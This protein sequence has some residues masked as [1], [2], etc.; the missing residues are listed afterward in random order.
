MRFKH[1]PG[2]LA[3]IAL[4]TLLAA[5]GGGGGGGGGDNDTPNRAPVSNAGADQSVFKGGA[6]TLDGSTSSDADGNSLSYRWTQSSG[7][8]VSLSSGTTSRPTFTAPAASGTLVF[9]LVVNDGRVDSTADTVQVTVA[10]RAPVAN[11]GTDATI[12]AGQLFTLDAMGSTDADT[13]A[14]TYTWTQLSG[15]AV[16]LTAVSNGRVR[17]T[18]PA[19]VSQLSFGV[20]ANDGEAGSTQDV[21]A[22]S[23]VISAINSPPVAQAY[24][25]FSMPKR[26]DAYLQGYGY[27]PENDPITFRWRQVGGPTVT[28]TNANSWIASFVAPETPAVLTFEFNVSDGVSISNTEVVVVTVENVAPDVY[29]SALSPANPRT[30]DDIAVDADFFDADSDPLTVTYTW[31]RNGTVVPSVTGAIFPASETTR[32]DV[33][34]VT[35]TANDGTVSTTVDAT[36]TILD[37]PPVL[38]A[39]A[40]TD[41]NYGD[42]V[43]FTVTASGDD[44]GDA[45]GNYVVRL[46]PAGFNVSGGGAAQWVA[47][48]PM[49]D[50]YVDVAWTVGL[51]DAPTAGVSGVIRVHHAAREVPIMRTAGGVPQNRELLVVTDLDG[52]GTD[53][54][55]ISDGRTLYVR[56]RSGTEFPENW[57]YPFSLA[58]VSNGIQSIAAANVSGDANAEIYVSSDSRIRMLDGTT[59]RLV[60]EYQP[61][62]V[63]QCNALRVADLEGDGPKEL[64]CLGMVDTYNSNGAGKIVVLNAADLSLKDTINQ[65]GLGTSMDVGNLDSDSALEIVTSNGYV[66]SGAT[67]INEWAYGPQ[68]G[69]VV[70]AGDVDGD[71]VEEIIAL[72][73]TD[74]KV[75]SAVT[76]NQR[77]TFTSGYCCGLGDVRVAE[78]GGDARRE[79]FIGDSQ[80][81]AVSAH[82]LNTTTQAFEQL[83]T[84]PSQGYGISGVAIGNVDADAN[85][86][87][88]WGTDIG[89]SANDAMI[90]AE[91]STPTTLTLQWRSD[92]AGQFTGPFVGGMLTRTA[93]GVRKVMFASQGYTTNTSGTRLIGLDPATGSPALS[94][95]IANTYYGNASIEVGDADSDGIDEVFISASDSYTPFYATHDF[96]S[97]TREWTSPTGYTASNGMAHADVTGDGNVD[98]ASMGTDARV[99]IFNVAQ[100]SVVWQSPQLEYNGQDVALGDVDEDGVTDVL[101]LTDSKIRVYGRNSTATQFVERAVA[102]VQSGSRVLAADLD[103]DGETEIVVLEYIYYYYNNSQL[104]VFD[105]NLQLLRTM[106]LTVRATNLVLEP[107]ANPRKNLLLSTTSTSGSYYYVPPTEVWAIDAQSGAGVWRSPALPGEFSRDSLNAVDLNADGQYELTFGTTVGAFITR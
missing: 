3:A 78:I 107:S 94:G 56:K 6:V 103:G 76:R 75:F 12:E 25:N 30:L 35:I 92:T 66:Y 11:A 86:E 22:I 65:T 29:A 8:T 37:T 73:S 16:T 43:N 99:T 48:L 47:K 55:L 20:V 17:F 101:A 46:G 64:I 88:V 81:G 52:D 63:T 49:F 2:G 84:L 14:L 40:P 21:V 95:I 98:F 97:D 27:D 15:P 61:P 38:S 57:A 96:A 102:D 51:A 4:T 7:P 104:R 91:I 31:K 23:V 18:A 50:D 36:T 39:N 82:R 13:D 89:S 93:T 100:S 32:G 106:P 34:L 41:V 71:G 80:W 105:K 59:R 77:Y 72:T 60:H 79:V 58:G 83:F 74:V 45:V 85:L 53:E 87:V 28:L 67:R 9:S 68:F 24:G 33:I 90:V 62:N 19:Q 1:R 44:D 10:N 5:C 54:M 26:G 42:T 70:E 69:T